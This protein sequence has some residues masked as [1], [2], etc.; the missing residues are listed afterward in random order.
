MDLVYLDFSKAFD[1]VFHSI[2]ITKL[3]RYGLDKWTIKWV[4]IWLDCQAQRV[5]IQYHY[6]V[7]VQLATSY[8]WCPLRVNTWPILFNVFMNDLDDGTECT[9]SKFVDDT[10]LEG[11]VLNML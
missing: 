10:K 7:V 9:L 11:G 1:M 2:V 8:Q 4:E 3:V 5:Q 6:S